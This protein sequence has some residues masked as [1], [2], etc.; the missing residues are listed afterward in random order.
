MKTDLE[1]AIAALTDW[2]EGARP[3]A[4]MYDRGQQAWTDD[5]G[6][7]LY[8]IHAIALFVAAGIQWLLRRGFHDAL[9]LNRTHG[10]VGDIYAIAKLDG[11]SAFTPASGSGP[12]L[13]ASIDSAIRSFPKPL[14]DEDQPHE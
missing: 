8:D 9:R 14:R 7:V 3:K 4:L 13:L 2:P 11:G 10:S 6:K 5:C 12:T 1:I